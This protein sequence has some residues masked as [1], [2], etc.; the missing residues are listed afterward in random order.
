MEEDELSVNFF[1]SVSFSKISPFSQL[2]R[3]FLSNLW[4]SSSES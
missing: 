3:S 2:K 1:E 4:E